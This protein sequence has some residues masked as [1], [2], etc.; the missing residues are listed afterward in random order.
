[1]KDKKFV[2]LKKKMIIGFT[3]TTVITAL[4]SSAFFL[5]IAM[6]SMSG[7]ACTLM[8][9]IATSTGKMIEL[10]VLESKKQG[11][12][13]NNEKINN[14]ISGIKI[15][16]T[17]NITI[18]DENGVIIASSDE[19]LA[20]SKYSYIEEAKSNESLKGIAEIHK[21]MLERKKGSDEYRVNGVRYV[22]AYDPIQGTLWSLEVSIKRSDLLVGKKSLETACFIVMIV[23]MLVTMGVSA[24]IAGYVATI[25]SKLTEKLEFI[26]K[27]NFNVEVE[28]KY[29]NMTSEI[30]I[31]ANSINNMKNS[32]KEMM[33]N[34]KEK[35]NDIDNKSEELSTLAEELASATSNINDAINEVAIGNGEQASG[36][37]E[38]TSIA[39]DF[40][41]KVEVVTKY[42]DNVQNNTVYI[43]NKAKL[44]KEAT[45]NMEEAVNKFDSNFN[46]FALEIKA[47]EGEMNTIT[48]IINIINGISDQTNLLALNAAIEA[49]RAGEAGKGFAVVADEIRNLAEQSKNSSEEIFRIIDKCSK[50]TKD[51]VDKSEEMNK[52]LMEQK[53]QIENILN[54]FEEIGVAV[55]EVIPDLNKTYREMEDLNAKKDSMMANIEEVSSISEEV[56]ASA[57]EIAASSSDLNK[58]SKDVAVSAEELTGNTADIINELEK[59]KL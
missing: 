53:L 16:D 35:A 15:L 8:E 58:S 3:L 30:G 36:I 52:D 37:N 20:S 33:I 27:G 34:I 42:I 54:V 1:M 59:F 29:L 38:I 10:S 31:I 13:V 5:K 19:I 7:N 48:S 41:N 9:E 24:Y 6:S 51:I 49:A 22:T 28:E 44:S 55:S 4:V 50:S 32:I 47:L 56:A 18:I 11:Y 12:T 14:L 25:I 39:E 21:K 45:A 40:V 57:Q 23:M 46:E 17:G 2:S 26:A 43:D